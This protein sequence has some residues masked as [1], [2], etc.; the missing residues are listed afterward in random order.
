MN[1]LTTFYQINQQAYLNRAY[2]FKCSY[3]LGSMSQQKE[4]QGVNFKV[5]I[6]KEKF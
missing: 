4:F 6:K 2:I 5:K 1:F 3:A